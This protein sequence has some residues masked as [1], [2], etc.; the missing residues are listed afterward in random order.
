MIFAPPTRSRAA[1]N[2]DTGLALRTFT[3][4]TLS[5]LDVGEHTKDFALWAAY[6]EIKLDR[7]QDLQH[8]SE[9]WLEA[10]EAQLRS[11]TIEIRPPEPSLEINRS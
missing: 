6:H 11:G 1:L 7:E 8:L 5:A 3:S 10:L 9:E 4:C 2:S